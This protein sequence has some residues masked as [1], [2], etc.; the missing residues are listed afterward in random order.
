MVFAAILLAAV[1]VINV[2]SQAVKE[3]AQMPIQNAQATAIIVV[4][5]TVH[6]MKLIVSQLT[7]VQIALAAEIISVVLLL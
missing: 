7:N 2:M 3:H 6:L 1:I 4:M 5:E